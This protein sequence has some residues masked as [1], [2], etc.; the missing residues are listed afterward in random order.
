MSARAYRPTAT[1]DEFASLGARLV[2]RGHALQEPS[3][4]VHELVALA[5]ACGIK[6]KMRAI[7]ESEG[8][9]DG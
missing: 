9:N 1:G 8:R 3:T 7:A 5:M 4:T 6:L 2:R